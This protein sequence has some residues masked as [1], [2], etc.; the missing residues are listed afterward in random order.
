[1]Y[2]VAGQP[3]GPVQG[4]GR[5]GGLL[6]RLVGEQPAGNP[7]LPQLF[8]GTAAQQRRLDQH[9]RP[10]AESGPH[11]G[12]IGNPGTVGQLESGDRRQRVGTRFRAQVRDV[13]RAEAQARTQDGLVPV[14]MTL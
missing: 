1:V 14:I 13:A 10:L 11:R 4:H 3:A 12:D 5:R 9:R 6:Q 8:G 2:D 7:Q